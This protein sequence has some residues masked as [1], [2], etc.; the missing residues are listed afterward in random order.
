M[1]EGDGE[2]D[3]RG[4]GRERPD[5]PADLQEVG[6]EEERHDQGAEAQSHEDIFLEGSDGL[7]ASRGVQGRVSRLPEGGHDH[8]GDGHHNERTCRLWKG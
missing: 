5:D 1:V 4:D 7:C 8:V 2:K 3:G 6:A